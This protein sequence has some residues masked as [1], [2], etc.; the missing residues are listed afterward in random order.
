MLGIGFGNIFSGKQ[1]ELKTKENFNKP[2]GSTRQMQPMPQPQLQQQ[3][4]QSPQHQ[5]QVYNQD[6]QVQMQPTAPGKLVQKL[7]PDLINTNNGKKIKAR[8]LYDYEP[9]QPDELKLVTGELIY[10]LDK[11]L[12]DEGWWKGESLSTGEVGVFP[13]NF[14]EQINEPQLTMNNHLNKG[15][16]MLNAVNKRKTPTAPYPVVN[17][18]NANNNNVM[19]NSNSN[20]SVKNVINDMNLLASSSSS[21]SSSSSASTS[22]SNNSLSKQGNTLINNNNNKQHMQH[23]SSSLEDQN[24]NSK[25]QSDISEDLEDIRENDRN[26]LTHIKKSTRQFNKRPPSFRSKNHK[27]WTFSSY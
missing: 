22:S 16:L 3:Q 2:N 9:T 7:P 21:S 18:V 20:G 10:I 17:N 12:E 19:A 4:Q 27:V 1:I 13:D 15:H 11:N 14:V 24:N 8:V 5:Q 25:S 6:L 23:I 26:K